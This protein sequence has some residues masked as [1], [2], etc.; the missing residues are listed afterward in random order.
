MNNKANNKPS[1][2]F[3]ELTPTDKL[4]HEDL[5]IQLLLIDRVD[6]LS[7]T[8]YAQVYYEYAIEEVQQA[9]RLFYNTFK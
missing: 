4:H 6:G 5:Y 9:G 7:N 8:P 1:L 3:T 2:Q